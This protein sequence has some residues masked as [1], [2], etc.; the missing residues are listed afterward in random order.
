LL[1]SEVKAEMQWLTTLYAVT[2]LSC[3]SMDM[4]QKVR[5]LCCILSL[6]SGITSFV[7]ALTGLEESMA[8]LLSMGLVQEVSKYMFICTV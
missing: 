6:N 1:S 4:R 2:L 5:Q 8:H 3:C 7:W